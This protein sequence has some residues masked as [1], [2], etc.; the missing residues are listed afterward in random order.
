MEINSISIE[1]CAIGGFLGGIVGVITQGSGFG[2][3]IFGTIGGAIG[4]VIGLL[5]F[6]LI[7]YAIA[8][9]QGGT[10]TFQTQ[11]ALLGTFVPPLLLISLFLAQI[12]ILGGIIGFLLFIYQLYLYIT[13]TQ[14]AQNVTA[15]KAAVA[16]LLPGVVFL[17]CIV[18]FGF[19]IAALILG[20]T[21]A[22]GLFR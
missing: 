16:V 3:V 18:V 14:A 13:A 8:N 9:A 1:S 17:C 12:P 15:G 22:G 10:G 5:I 21:A 2:S 19:G 20:G 7:V 11:V 4:A 6:A